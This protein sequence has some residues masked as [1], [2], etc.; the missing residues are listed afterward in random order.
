VSYPEIAELIVHRPPM[1]LLDRLVDTTETS[2]TCEVTL[3]TDSTFVRQGRARAIVSLE[4]MAQC[5]GVFAGYQ[6][7]SR[8]EKPKI[9]YLVGARDVVLEVDTLEAGDR[10]LVRAEH[11]WVCDRAA[12]FKCSVKRET[13]TIAT[14]MLSVYMPD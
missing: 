8:S 9:G 7:F 1:L 12:S 14:A 4:Y 3:R 10:L 11:L 13:A 5:V 2:V 6:R